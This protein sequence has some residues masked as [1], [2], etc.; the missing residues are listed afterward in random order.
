[1]SD[2]ASLYRSLYDPSLSE[3]KMSQKPMG[4]DESLKTEADK[5]V[6]AALTPE[7]VGMKTAAQTMSAGGTLGQTATGGAIGAIAAGAPVMGAAGAVGAAGLALSYMESQKQAEAAHERAVI[8]EATNRKNAV[9]AAI[10]GQM[11]A[12]RLLGVT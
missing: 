12:A 7:Q 2:S 8:E 11:N 10:A 4:I 5:N 1:M 6:A 9:Q 3:F